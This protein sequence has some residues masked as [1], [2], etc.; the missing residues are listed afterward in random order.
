MLCEKYDEIIIKLSFI[1][2]ATHMLANNDLNFKNIL[3]LSS[4]YL[5]EPCKYPA[6]TKRLNEKFKNL[7]E[8]IIMCRLDMIKQNTFDFLLEAEKSLDELSKLIY[9]SYFFGKDHLNS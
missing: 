3:S 1:E 4:S 9:S 7:G 8:C 5:D 2:S 6:S